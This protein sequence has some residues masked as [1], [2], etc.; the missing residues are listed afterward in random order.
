[1]RRERNIALNQ[2]LLDLALKASACYALKLAYTER[3]LNKRMWR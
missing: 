3:A 2:L 1:M